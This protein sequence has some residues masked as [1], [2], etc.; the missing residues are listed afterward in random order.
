MKKGIPGEQGRGECLLFDVSQQYSK[1]G[2]IPILKKKS[3]NIKNCSR[4]TKR[5]RN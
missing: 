5:T 2:K 1:K 3:L 4:T